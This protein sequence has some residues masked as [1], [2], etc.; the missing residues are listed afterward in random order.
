MLPRM[1]RSH[2]A[3]FHHP[4]RSTAQ[5]NAPSTNTKGFITMTDT[6]TTQEQSVVDHLNELMADD[7]QA[8]TTMSRADLDKLLHDAAESR[9]LL[10]G[11][12]HPQNVTCNL[13][14]EAIQA[15]CLRRDCEQA[16]QNR[17]QQRRTANIA[18]AAALID[19]ASE[20]IEHAA[21]IPDLSAAPAPVPEVNVAT[22][23]DEELNVM[24]SVVVAIL[25]T[26]AP[27]YGVQAR[28]IA[29]FKTP[30]SKK[31]A[32]ELK[33]KAK[34]DEQRR[35]TAKLTAQLISAEQERREQ[36]RMRE[37][38]ERSPEGQIDRIKQR[39]DSLESRVG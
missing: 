27:E 4:N 34:A 16:E 19:E 30:E 20:L 37:E 8:L 1:P 38:Y 39:L 5:R 23:S 36:A 25:T 29:L 28:A 13:A 35:S 18:K 33:R 7:W 10:M 12:E 14:I 21:A 31:I 3:K 2:G 11:F 15:E 26:P 22:A 6:N 17:K 24:H 32:D 9:A